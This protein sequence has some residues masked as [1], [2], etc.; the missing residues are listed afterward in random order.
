LQ[1]NNF[2]DGDIRSLAERLGK[3]VYFFKIFEENI[4]Y[5]VE[6]GSIHIIDNLTRVVLD[7]GTFDLAVL[8][9][10]LE[11]VSRQDIASVLA[12]LRGLIEQGVLF[13]PREAPPELCGT[14]DE[15]KALCLNVAHA[16]NMRCGY[17]FACDGTYGKAAAIMSPVVACAAIDFLFAASNGRRHLEVDFFGGEPLLALDTVKTAVEYGKARAKREGKILKFTLT[18][19]ALVLDSETADYLNRE[20]IST[21][22]SLDGRESTNDRMRRTAGGEGTYQTIAPKILAFVRSRGS[23]EYYVRGT[24]TRE[25]MDFASDVMHLAELGLDQISVEPAVNFS[26]QEWGIRRE[27]LA[28]LRQEYRRLAE[29]CL[30]RKCQGEAIN[31]FHFNVDLSDGPCAAKRASGCGAGGQYLAVDPDGKIWPCHQFVGQSGFALGDV[32]QGIKSN[33]VRDSFRRASLLNKSECRECWARYH[34][35]GGCH[36]NAWSE[37]KDLMRPHQ[38][39]CELMRMRLECALALKVK[40][41]LADPKVGLL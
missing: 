6:S 37:S 32:F 22:L 11:H 39:G 1:Q 23:C 14:A 5:D 30:K 21:V 25:N 2:D 36:A 24:F 3:D 16:C 18:T 12:E 38:V 41:M 29:Y 40:E 20:K 15:V 4:L 28:G 33:Q 26:G 35:G 8:A 27:D 34:C 10:E 13:A 7:K 19:N 17:C 9:K 31:F